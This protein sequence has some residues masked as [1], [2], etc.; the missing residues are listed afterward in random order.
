MV[1]TAES[2]KE[3]DDLKLKLIEN[4]NEANSLIKAIEKTTID[5]KDRLTSDELIEIMELINNVKNAL[6]KN[7]LKL[8]KRNV[9]RLSIGSQKIF[10]TKYNTY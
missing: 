6:E 9:E 1:E 5:L 2:H 3:E 8:I 4:R 7:E 10:S